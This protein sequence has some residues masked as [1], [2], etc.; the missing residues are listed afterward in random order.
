MAVHKPCRSKGCRAS[1]R[2]SHPW[3]LTYA[4][5]KVVEHDG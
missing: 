1:A 3:W 2:C 4:G 5:P